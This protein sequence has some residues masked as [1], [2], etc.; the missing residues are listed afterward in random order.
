MYTK[1]HGWIRFWS[2]AQ[3]KRS[4]PTIPKAATLEGRIMVTTIPATSRIMNARSK[5]D[6]NC[7]IAVERG[8]RGNSLVLNHIGDERNIEA[9]SVHPSKTRRRMSAPS[10]RESSFATCEVIGGRAE[11]IG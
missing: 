7:G 2:C 6:E 3:R 5:G 4:D 11:S 10:E 8:T 9:S 1:T